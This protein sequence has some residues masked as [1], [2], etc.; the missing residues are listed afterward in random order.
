MVVITLVVC[1]LLY[2]E[3]FV[4]SLVRNTIFY[5][6]YLHWFIGVELP[7]TLKLAETMVIKT[8]EPY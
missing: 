8:T 7:D 2:I 3:F 6:A 5:C 1:N 4:V